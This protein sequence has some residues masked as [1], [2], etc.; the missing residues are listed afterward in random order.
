MG[1]RWTEWS[2]G[3]DGG[4]LPGQGE[5]DGDPEHGQVQLQGRG[6]LLGRVQ[7]DQRECDPG[8]EV[9]CH[10]RRQSDSPT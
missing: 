9:M 2:G 10:H 1:D 5:G 3:D 7:E 6:R 4:R 8:Q